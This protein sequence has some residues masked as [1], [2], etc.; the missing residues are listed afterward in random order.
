MLRLLSSRRGG[1]LGKWGRVVTISVCLAVGAAMH[2]SPGESAAA[3]PKA[4]AS[5]PGKGPGGGEPQGKPDR[6]KPDKPGKPK[7]EPDPNRQSSPGVYSGYSEPLY[8]EQTRTSLY[9]PMRDGTRIAVDIFRPAVNGVAVNTPHPVIW[10]HQLAR[11]T[12]NPNG[13]IST[14]ANAASAFTRYGYV[15][16]YADRRGNGASFG[17]MRGYHSRAEAEDA[18]DLMEWFASQPWSDGKI[19]VFGC[20]N[21]GEAAMH[22]A[23]AGSP[24]LRA[25]FAGNYS[26]HKYDGFNR[27][28]IRANWGVGPNRTL[29]QDLTNLP[30]DE[31]TDGSLLY[32]AALE[33]LDNTSLRDMWREAPYRDS[34]V[35]SVQARPWEDYSIATY[36]KQIERSGV[37]IYSWDG[38][39]DD[40][41][42][43]IL[44]SASSLKNPH[45]VL[46]GPWGHCGNTGFN[47]PLEQLR[48]FDYWLKGI[49][50]GI[51]DEPAYY[52]YTERSDRTGTWNHTKQRPGDG[53]KDMVLYF[54]GTPS[55]TIASV[56]DGTLSPD[57]PR[58][59]QGEDVYTVNYGLTCPGSV[60]LGQTCSQGLYGLTYT[61]APLQ[62]D[63]EV[64]GHPL[65]EL[66]LA[67]TAPEQ[68]VF[69]YI[70]DV[71]PN[72][73]V[74]VI[75]DGRLKASLRATHKASWDVLGTPWYRA[76]ARDARWLVPGQ[77]T[78]LKIDVLP[79][80]HVFQAGHRVRLVIT[81]ADVRESLRTEYDPAPVLTVFRSAPKASKLVLPVTKPRGPHQH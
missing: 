13:S 41:R 2:A 69:V 71:A 72:G 74:R 4:D 8:S 37:A 23:T 31:D 6:P 18:Y 9:V 70:E 43:E 33:H 78:Q 26:F 75:T 38:W 24:H 10:E 60:G 7:P 57:H 17:V 65:V 28:G 15:V 56:N 47:L 79:L 61:S 11:A 32:Q 45:K 68:H 73:T 81:G 40:F 53:A 29:E 39:Q 42:K 62:E 21:T 35:D 20:S 44:T 30:V 46:I 63:L 51:M 1:E 48:F 52:W 80:S 36:R 66:T 25:V 58:G 77:P 67:S 64:T 54:S 59:N 19:G 49:D 76:E 27:G 34:W 12:R 55:G 3:S 22:A 50:N 16:A 5:A 14:R